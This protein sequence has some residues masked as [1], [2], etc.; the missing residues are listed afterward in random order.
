MTP[1]D[2]PADL[3]LRRRL[4][5]IKLV[6]MA[7]FMSISAPYLYDLEHGNRRFSTHHRTAYAEGLSALRQATRDVST[8]R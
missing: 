6:D 8:T 3:R 5:N 1:T 7:E 4:A 2:S